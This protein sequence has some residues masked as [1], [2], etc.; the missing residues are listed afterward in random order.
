MER[1]LGGHRRM[2]LSKFEDLDL[3]K[4]DSVLEEHRIQGMKI[5]KNIYEQAGVRYN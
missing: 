4:S 2:V 5:A 3:P 1:D